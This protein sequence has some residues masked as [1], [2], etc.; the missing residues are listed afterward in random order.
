[1]CH[2]QSPIVVAAEVLFGLNAI[3]R[4][5]KIN[6]VSPHRWPPLAASSGRHH[7]V[8]GQASRAGSVTYKR[9]K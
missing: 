3:V 8:T 7:P 9:Y 2:Y 1:M 6:V 4:S 5:V